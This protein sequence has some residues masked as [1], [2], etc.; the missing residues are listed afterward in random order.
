MYIQYIIYTSL[1]SFVVDFESN[2]LYQEVYLRLNGINLD[3][4]ATPAPCTSGSETVCPVKAGAFNQYSA[5][6]WFSSDLPPVCHLISSSMSQK[7]SDFP[8]YACQYERFA[9]IIR[10]LL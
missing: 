9:S 7:K 6:V 10:I 2:F 1:V 3:V 8:H 5:V 4:E